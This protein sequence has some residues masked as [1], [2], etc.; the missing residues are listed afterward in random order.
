M[1]ATPILNNGLI[2]YVGGYQP[3]INDTQA[4]QNTQGDAS[5]TPNAGKKHGRKNTFSAGTS[6]SAQAQGSQL[7]MLNVEYIIE[8]IVS[9]KNQQS[10]H[11]SLKLTSQEIWADMSLGSDGDQDLD[12]LDLNGHSVLQLP[13]LDSILILG[14]R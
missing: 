5:S 14:G 1:A 9:L 2:L 11:R 4:S 13:E 6:N 3:E 12:K 7:L 8:R 10:A